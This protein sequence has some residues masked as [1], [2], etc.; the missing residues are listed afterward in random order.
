MFNLLF[1]NQ[2]CF[3]FLLCQ[4]K[5]KRKFC[6]SSNFYLFEKQKKRTF[7]RLYIPFVNNKSKSLL[8]KRPL[9]TF[10]CSRVLNLT[11]WQ[12]QKNHDALRWHK[13]RQEKKLDKFTTKIRFP[14]F[15]QSFKFFPKNHVV[16]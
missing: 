13:Q 10:F 12:N 9:H 1:K 2:K 7:K 11:F 16:F 6:V 3:K 14:F 15:F 8:F 5:L 4:T